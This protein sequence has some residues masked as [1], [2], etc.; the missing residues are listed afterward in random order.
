MLKLG[1][2]LEVL[3]ASSDAAYLVSVTKNVQ[4]AGPQRGETVL[5]LDSDTPVSGFKAILTTRL[6]PPASGLGT[7]VFRASAELSYLDEGDILRLN[8]LTGEYRTL[9]R[10]QSDHNTFLLTERC[11]H[12]CLMCSQPPK[13]GDD[14]WLLREAHELLC[15]LPLDTTR[16]GFSG[17]E[18]TL[19]GGGFLELLRFAK[20][21]LPSM[22]IDVLSN[23]RAFSSR[24]FAKKYAQ[25]DHP[26]LL[27]GIP[28]YSDDPVIHDYVVQSKG[29][30]DQTVR[31]ILNLK[32]EGQ[33][34]EVRIVIHQQTI[35]RL[36]KTCEFIARNLLFVDHV[37]LMGLELTGFTQENL[38]DLWIDPFDYKDQLSEA[39]RWLHVYGVSVSVYNHP[40]CV[41]NRDVEPHYKRSISDWK[42]EYLQEC[43][44][45]SRKLECGGLFSSAVQHGYS[46]H[47]R[48][49]H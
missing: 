42:R 30:F 24:A 23:G 22:H 32:E 39:V 37:A 1:G 12:Y 18:P 13:E 34:V 27:I 33:K 40:L 35:G 17:G 5:M 19:Y 43:Q 31:G 36:V 15:R 29:A 6:R 4:L 38:E 46:S 44:R 45:C 16:I 7:D 26:H 25:I 9:F 2:T 10:R 47:I 11:N 49:F 28:L 20:H 48:A 8:P 14:S 3:R 41:V 21:R